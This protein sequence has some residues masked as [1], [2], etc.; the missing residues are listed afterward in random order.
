MWRKPHVLKKL[1]A[2]YSSISFE[3]WGD[4][5]DTINPV[6]LINQQ[7]VHLA[8]VQLFIL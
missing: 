1:S 2:A 3:H 5:P 4:L 7:N 8:S 6:E